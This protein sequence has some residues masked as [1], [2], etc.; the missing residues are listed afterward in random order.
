MAKLNELQIKRLTSFIGRDIFHEEGSCRDYGE[1]SAAQMNDLRK[2]T[3]GGVFLDAVLYVNFLLGEKSDLRSAASFVEN[4]IKEQMSVE[5]WL[6]S[7]K[8]VE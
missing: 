5:V 4:V 3:H 2:L 7:V 1:V 8:A 6:N